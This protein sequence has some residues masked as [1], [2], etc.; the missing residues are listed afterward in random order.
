[1]VEE[2]GGSR[3]GVAYLLGICLVAALGGLLFGF[4][5]AVVS[6]TVGFFRA[7]FG[8]SASR[9]GWTASSALIGCML[10][11]AMAGVLSDRFGR[12]RVLLLSAVFFTASAVGCG[13][14]D[15]AD[16]LVVW[17]IVG[18]MG[19]GVASMI[20]PLYIAEIAPPKV[21][22][23][24]VSLQQFAIIS[25]ILAAYF[26]NSV[27]LHTDLADA[28]KWRW[29]FAVGA[30]PAVVFLALLFPI[31]ESPRWLIKQ[32]LTEKAEPVLARI[33]GRDDTAAQIAE[34]RDAIA[35]ESG[36]I[37]ELFGPGLRRALWVG[38][39]LAILQQVTG[40][41]AILYYAPEI[42]K[43]AGAGAERAFNDTVWIGVF[44]MIFTVVAMS[45]IDR[46][47]RKPLLIAGSI[48]M[49]LSL[50]VLA[51]AFDNR[52]S[53]I[54]LLVFILAYV[55]CF[56]ASQGPV[57]WVIM[58][59]IFP[60]RIRGRAMSVATVSL[61]AGCYLVSQTFPMLIDATGGATAFRI[62]AA[63][64]VATIV[65]VWLAVPETRRRSL[66]DIERAWHRPR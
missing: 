25:G 34:I 20:S 40:I 17:R 10:G 57:V 49:G 56:A 59:E 58:S 43:G 46:I 36:S 51:A 37:K 30:F 11:A 29:M 12:K 60:T 32:G 1:M 15:T 31:P 14:A 27:I 21:R 48:G 54:W 61:W 38:V 22:G 53:G 35:Q 65:F 26:S 28:A 55:S 52:A 8:L 6:G 4:D 50:L 5:T 24:L 2:G 41:N 13:V 18:G 19:I 64:C 62:Y 39:V 7:E 33:S 9:T 42:F 63:F 47:G 45:V 44:N 23:L 3:R 16:D 66:E